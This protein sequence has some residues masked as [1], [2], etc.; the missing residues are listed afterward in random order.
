MP[1]QFVRTIEPT[2]VNLAGVCEQLER[3]AA[4]YDAVFVTDCDNDR[5]VLVAHDPET[6]HYVPFEDDLT[7]AIAVDHVLATL[8]PGRTVV[9]NWSTSQ[10]IK[11]ICSAHHANLRRV[12]TGEVFTSSDALHFHA[13][14]AGEGSCAGVIDPRV[15]M[16]RDVLVAM[17]HVLAALAHKRQNLM[18]IIRTFPKYE[19]SRRDHCLKASAERVQGMI[20]QLQVFYARKTDLAFMSREDGLIVAFQDNS[21]IQIR[22][23]NTEP[24]LRVRSWSRDAGK[25]SLLAEEA[26]RAIRR[27]SE[28]PR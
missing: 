27:Y 2:P 4:P 1:G 10:V 5:C 28:G 13:A 21:R 7:F 25:A 14:L 17:W 23:S 3:D 9:T 19:K 12:P 16:G 22:A 20:E 18:G 11:D 15:G 24:L 8:P 26:I 6:G